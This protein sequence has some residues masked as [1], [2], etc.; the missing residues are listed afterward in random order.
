MLRK[1]YLSLRHDNTIFALVQ[2]LVEIVFPEQENRYIQSTVKQSSEYRKLRYDMPIFLEGRPHN[3]Q[4]ICLLNIERGKKIPASLIVQK[5]PT[6]NFTVAKST[7]NDSSEQE[8]TW[9]VSIPDG[10]C[11]CPSF[12]LSNI[13]CKHVFAILFHFPEWTWDDLPTSLTES[14][15]MLLD[16]EVAKEDGDLDLP[17]TVSECDFVND[18]DSHESQLTTNPLPVTQSNAKHIYSLQKKLEEALAQCRTLAFLTT[19]VSALNDALRQC[20]E[21]SRTLTSAAVMPAQDSHVL[22]VFKAITDE[23]K[24]TRKTIHRV[25]GIKRRF[26]NPN[27]SSKKLK[28]VDA[29]QKDHLKG[30]VSI[31]PGRPK[32][33]RIRKKLK[34]PR[35]VSPDV[36]AKLMRAT[37]I[38]KRG[39]LL[40][41]LTDWW[42]ILW[43]V[44][45]YRA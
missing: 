13:P 30:V 9:I 11:T 22:P 35:Q 39:K 36:V 29:V 5:D 24:Q 28:V 3:I 23:F 42:F 1:R 27:S 33:R 20:T 44:C 32:S 19:D 12:V 31:T 40:M 37:A 45:I 38:L 14:S 18:Q 8:H 26:S 34:F 6:G 16:S 10:T 15:H 21:V 7:S 41:T 17:L 25:S 2:V 4:S 43:V